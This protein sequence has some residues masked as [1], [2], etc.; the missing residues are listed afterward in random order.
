MSHSNHAVLL[1][2]LL[3]N[4]GATTQAISDLNP[5][6]DNLISDAQKHG[7]LFTAKLD[8]GIHGVI[9]FCQPHGTHKKHSVGFEYLSN[10]RP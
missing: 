9:L 8:N 1:Q 7:A 6:I 3:R 2:Y 5:K 4:V 10:L